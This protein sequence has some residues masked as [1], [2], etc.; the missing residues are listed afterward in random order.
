V[1]WGDLPP[2][3]ARP[4]KDLLERRGLAMLG[5]LRSD[6]RPRLGPVEAHLVDS[7][8]LIGVMP[9]FG[10]WPAGK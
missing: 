8:L 9:R 2:G 10:I 1:S 6:G 5:T 4:G 3:I 7:R